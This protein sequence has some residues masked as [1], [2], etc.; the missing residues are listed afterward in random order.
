MK[1]EEL[2]A[3]F[4]KRE[5]VRSY[6]AQ[7]VEKDK[8]IRCLEAARLSPSACN[9]QPWK[10]I[11]VDEPV[12][13]TKLADL[14]SS[15]IL[16]M[17][18]FT[19][20]APILLVIVRE[21]AN[22]TSNVGQFLKNKE[23]PLIDIGITAIQF[24]LQAAAEGLGTCILGWFDEKGVR[25]LLGIPKTKRVELIITLGYPA[26]ETPRKKIRKDLNTMVAFNQYKNPKP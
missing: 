12:L 8:L 20:Q 7:S 10:W 25:K 21:P 4:E 22:F 26:R 15:K 23:Y 24:C 2:M 16:S 13:K 6:L 17:N 3:L 11:V 9:A 14:T 18:H 5:S 19:K 1:P